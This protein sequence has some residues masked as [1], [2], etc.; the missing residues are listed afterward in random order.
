VVALYSGY[1]DLRPDTP[2]WPDRDRFILSK[3]HACSTL[4]TELG[5][6]GF[7]DAEELATFTRLGSRFGDH[8]DMRKIPGIDFSSGS[9]GHGLSVGAGMAEALRL[10]GR[11][12]RVV[13][14]VGDG[15]LNE[16]QNWEAIAYASARRLSNLLALVDV[17]G[18]C[19][20]GRV[21]H[22]VGM[23]PLVDKWQAFGWQVIDIDGHDFEAIGDALSRYDRSRAGGDSPPTVVIARTV[24]AKGVPFIEDDAEWHIG[25]LA[26]EDRERAVGLISTMFEEASRA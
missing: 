12:N 20:N 14:L 25:Y 19:V 1:L 15:E 16:G 17:N 10:Q 2:D 24:S 13:V 8:P 7:F 11:D 6:L 22:G 26:G 9:L 21:E 5:R 4:Y 23:E 18:V 3:G